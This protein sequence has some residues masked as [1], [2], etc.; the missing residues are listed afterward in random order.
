MEEKL[1]IA[2]E[3]GSSKIKGATGSIGPDGT[4]TVK[5]VEEEPISDIVRYGCI[6][7]IAETAQAVQNVISR[8]EQREA[9]RKIEGVYITIGG[10]SLSTKSSE[11]ER[12]FPTETIITEDI[13]R[14]IIQETLDT[15]LHDRAIVDVTPREILIDNISTPK[16]VGVFGSHILARLNIVHCR[17]QL[18]R[19]LHVVIE[20]RLGLRIMDR[21]VR[22]LAIADLVLLNEEKKLGCMLVDF[23]AETTTVAIYRGG[24]LQHL[25]VLPMG[26]RNITRDITAL[27]YL[28]EEAEMLKCQ[29]GS[30]L[31]T[32]DSK[33]VPGQPDFVA[34]NN[35]ASARA[36]EIIVNIAEQIKYAGL[37]P[38]KLA[39]GIIIVGRGAR[40]SDFNK[41]L[42]Q[43]TGLTVRTGTPGNR[44]RILDGGIQVSDAVDVIAILNKAAQTGPKQCVS[45]PT[46]PKPTAEPVQQPYA[47]QPY[48]QQQ[49]NPYGRPVA[50]AAA[51]QQ[52][53]PGYAQPAAP[54][55][56]QAPQ[57][58]P[59]YAQPAAPA[60][61]Q[62]PQPV[63][64]PQ[65]NPYGQPAAATPQP[66]QPAAAPVT[67]PQPGYS[68]E[69]Q[70]PATAPS[71]QVGFNQ[72]AQHDYGTP[73]VQ[74]PIAHGS[75]APTPV[76]PQTPEQENTGGKKGWWKKLSEDLKGRVTNLITD[77]FEEEDDE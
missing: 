25:A 66:G 62:A 9:P 52:P 7:N 59:G 18:V 48:V 21:F 3:I 4:L 44:V 29:R 10:R 39:K 23:G 41:R 68:Q 60:A 31:P 54:A 73:Q 74:R 20:D 65:T 35:Y 1:I 53:V 30:A 42:E 46:A 28:E 14:D 2:L 19:T 36:G 77:T 49:V 76:A 17:P 75:G 58:A 51:P 64:G 26:S 47:Q 71:P 34:I 72:P 50:P 8:L 61:A 11:V 40:L 22:P 70:N 69:P 37:T 67:T 15:P 5:A 57:P 6:R 32:I 55:A 56:A 63:Y 16:P 24:V 38:E 12:L 33:T 27:N 43:L 45:D 13:I